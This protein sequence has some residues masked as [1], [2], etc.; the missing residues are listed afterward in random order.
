MLLVQI[1]ISH[2]KYNFIRNAVVVHSTRMWIPAP[3]HAPM[4]Y[5]MLVP[6]AFLCYEYTV[7]KQIISEINMLV[8][9]FQKN[10]LGKMML[11]FCAYACR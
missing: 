6:Y 8:F 3:V 4:T 5:L 11:G 7:F 9:I 1:T 10:L 2:K